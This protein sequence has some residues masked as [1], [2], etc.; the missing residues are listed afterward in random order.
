MVPS[1][2]CL[3]GYKLGA[4]DCSR[5]APSCGNFFPVLNHVVIPDLRAG[6]CCAVLR[7]SLLTVS[8]CV[9]HLICVIKNYFALLFTV[10][11]QTA[12]STSRHTV[13]VGV[14]NEVGR[15]ENIRLDRDSVSQM[16]HNF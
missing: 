6:M 9:C 3:R 7:G 1:G 15:A 2:E 12:A 11:C 13:L 4:A 8:K 14:M 16:R 10:Q 5:L